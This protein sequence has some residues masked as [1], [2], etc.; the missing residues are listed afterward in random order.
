LPPPRPTVNPSIAAA[1]E[2]FE[3]GKYQEAA[4][5]LRAALAREPQ[6]SSLVFWLLRNCYELEMTDEAIRAGEQAVKLEPS[7]SEYHQWLG[8][9][10]GQKADKTRSFSYARKTRAEFE[11]AVNLNPA[12]LSA[13]RDLMEFYLNAPWILG[14]GKEKGSRQAEAIAALDPVEG[15]LARGS[16]W[17]ILGEPESAAAE[18]AKVMDLKPG[19]LEPYFEVADFYA[20]R[21]DATHLEATLEAAAIVNTH[22]FRV[23][24]YRG[25]ACILARKHPAEAEEYLKAYLATAPSR[26]D[27]PSHASAHVWLGR[28]YEQL[29]RLQLAAEQFKAALQLAPSNK[30]ASGGLRRTTVA[31]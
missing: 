18:Y 1:R 30:D 6:D 26:H 17:Q 22:D 25:V 15:C 5:L 10:Y 27:Y 24:Y 20:S 9:T 4:S 11:T 31:R 8:R 2:K 29:G 19:K 28:L 13:R 3:A 7:N 12:N 21:Q 23:A 16:Y 14:G